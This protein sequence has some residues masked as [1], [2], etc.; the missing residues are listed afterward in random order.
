MRNCM[1][2]SSTYRAIIQ[3]GKK[4]P[5]DLVPVPPTAGGPLL[6]LPNALA[7]WQN[8]SNQ[9]QQEVFYHSEWSPCMGSNKKVP[10][11][12]S[13]TCFV[14]AGGL[15]T[16]CPKLV[17]FRMAENLNLTNFFAP[18]CKQHYWAYVMQTRKVIQLQYGFVEQTWS[19]FPRSASV[20]RLNREAD[21]HRRYRWLLFR[22][23]PS[24]AFPQLESAGPSNQP[25]F[26]SRPSCA[27]FQGI[28]L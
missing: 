7:G 22:S 18:L 24:T 19:P 15:S 25:E 9:S 21:V 3:N 14:R 26:R 23:P 8:I 13:D 12:V 5:V 10:A 16:G 28:Y 1:I 17:D 2:R 11:K 20:L 4:P 27:S 6:Q